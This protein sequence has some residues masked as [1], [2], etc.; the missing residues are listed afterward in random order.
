[1]NFV[2]EG[3]MKDSKREKSTRKKTH[4]QA[5]NARRDEKHFNIRNAKDEKEEKEKLSTFIHCMIPSNFCSWYLTSCVPRL[6]C[7]FFLCEWANNSISSSRRASFIAFEVVVDRWW[8][9]ISKTWTVA[10]HEREII[11]HSANSHNI[12]Y[13]TGLTFEVESCSPLT[14]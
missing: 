8:T 2:G 6:R 14:L 4:I 10:A 7:F 13:N 3:W 12:I 11:L 1:M 9:F 5:L